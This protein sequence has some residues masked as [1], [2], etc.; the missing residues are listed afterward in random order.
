MECYKTN[1]ES[2]KQDKY[3]PFLEDPL[4]NEQERDSIYQFH[5]LCK[6][7][8]DD[9]DSNDLSSLNETV[10]GIM[11]FAYQIQNPILNEFKELNLAYYLMKFLDIDQTPNAITC[12]SYCLA[13][14][15]EIS[16]FF[17][18]NGFLQKASELLG[19][20]QFISQIITS[21]GNIAACSNVNVSSVLKIISY[22]RIIQLANKYI[23]LKDE[24]YCNKLF[25]LLMN[26]THKPPV[27]IDAFRFFTQ[28]L[29][30]PPFPSV[31]KQALWCLHYSLMKNTD[32]KNACKE[33]N[34][35]ENMIQLIKTQ[36]DEDLQ[37]IGLTLIHDIILFFPENFNDFD[38]S[39]IL[40]F[41]TSQNEMLN[42]SAMLILNEMSKKK[43]DQ[44]IKDDF[45]DLCRE[46]LTESPFKLKN[47]ISDILLSVIDN[48]NTTH[49]ISLLSQGIVELLD[50]NFDSDD[51]YLLKKTVKAL[52]RLISAVVQYSLDNENQS[53]DEDSSE[54]SPI[55]F[56]TKEYERLDIYNKI[57][58]LSTSFDDDNL[59]KEI[60]IFRSAYKKKIFGVYEYS[61]EEE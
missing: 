12:I 22:D 44:L 60:R 45:L 40:P 2:N 51:I 42:K 61:D 31:L 55:Q 27:P 56:L 26:L 15:D 13:H 5:L 17:V 25:R 10:E 57:K 16:T 48:L 6:K 32:L 49:L 52:K 58:N 30:D 38:L 59:E 43:K 50:N 3:T 34:L 28:I 54:L 4:L 11:K 1:L 19:K 35:F 46:I 41:L 33:N 37:Y 9:I 23:S 18:E 36:D 24:N 47:K 14:E 8:V 21:L 20:D 39:L 53:G 7:F 29:S